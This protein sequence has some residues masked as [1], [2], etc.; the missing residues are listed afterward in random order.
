MIILKKQEDFPIIYLR[1]LNN[2]LMYI[3]ES[4]GYW[5]TNRHNRIATRVD[6]PGDF[7][8]IIVLKSVKNNRRRKYWE[9]LLIS[10]MKPKNQKTLLYENI[11]KRKNGR[12]PEIIKS[13]SIPIEKATKKEILYAAYVRLD[14]FKKLMESYKL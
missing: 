13:R 10:K 12:E 6:N 2:E 8:K 11:V 3:G 1:Y 9:A 7:D 4:Y 14:Q 5:R